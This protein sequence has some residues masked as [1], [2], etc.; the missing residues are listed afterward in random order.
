MSGAEGVAPRKPASALPTEAE[1]RAAWAELADW[2]LRKERERPGA[3][4]VSADAD[5]A[6]F[7]LVAAGA[8]ERRRHREELDAAGLP[9]SPAAE[10]AAEVK[11]VRAV[12]AA[13]D[14]TP[15]G[16]ALAAWLRLAL[17]VAETSLAW[18]SDEQA[19]EATR[20]LRGIGR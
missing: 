18:G 8:E 17:D 13:E 12:L 11:R 4:A 14:A 15:G 6:L 3:L 9:P 5:L 20:L 7:D 2:M 19:R 1:D 10:L 16:E